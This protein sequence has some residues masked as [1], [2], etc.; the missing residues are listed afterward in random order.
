MCKTESVYLG[1]QRQAVKSVQQKEK[2]GIYASTTSLYRVT[3]VVADLGWVDF[4][5]DASPSSQVA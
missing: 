1:E 3:L 5:S 2:T 4:D